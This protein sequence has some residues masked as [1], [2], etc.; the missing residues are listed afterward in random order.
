MKARILKLQGNWIK[1]ER[2]DG[3]AGWV[4][5]KILEKIF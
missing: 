2:L 4:D 1:I 5:R 3:K